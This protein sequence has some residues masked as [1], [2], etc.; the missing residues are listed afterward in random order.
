M[1]KKAAKR[2]TT[3]KLPTRELTLIPGI[4]KDPRIFAANRNPKKDRECRALGLDIGTNCGYSLTHFNPNSGEKIS[5]CNIVCGQLDL[6]LGPF[7]SGGV[8]PVKLRQ[9]LYVIQPDIIFFEDVKNVPVGGGAM[10]AA[11]LLARAVP[12]IEVMAA[13]KTVITVYAFDNDIPCVGI[14][15]AHIKRRATGKGNANKLDIIIAAMTEFGVALDT[16]SYETMGHDNVA[17]AMFCLAIGVDEYGN[18]VVPKVKDEQQ[19]PQPPQFD[20]YASTTSQPL[21]PQRRRSTGVIVGGD[22]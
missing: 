12:T 19:E 7:D 18:G 20:I 1:A 3:A 15:I 21:R 16:E 5:D 9:F 4:E 8:R 17:D 10:N 14:P 22:G 11:A 6:S 2:T 13:L